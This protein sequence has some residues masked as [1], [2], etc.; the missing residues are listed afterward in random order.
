MN[1]LHTRWAEARL[2]AVAAML[3]LSLAACA[4]TTEDIG[5]TGLGP[6]PELPS[7]Q[8]SL[9][10]TIN[11]AP[12]QTRSSQSIPIAPPGFTVTAFASGLEH[13]RWVYPLPDGDLLVA[14][15][16]APAQHDEHGGIVGWVR[17]QVM[18]FVMK[19]AGAGV[20]SPDRIVL[21]RGQG[22][23]AQSRSVLISGLHSPF[24][25]A[26]VGDSLYVADTDALL[27]FPY[28]AGDTQI[29]AA[30]EKVADLPAGPINHHWTKNVV[31]S[32]D[33]Q[34]LYVTVGSNSNVGENGIEAEEGRAMILEFTAATGRSRVFAAGL[35]N[36]NGMDWQPE[37]GA[38][39]AAVNERDELGDNLVPDYMTAVKDGGFYGF[40]YSYYGQHVDTR[41]K[42]QRPD[43]VASALT[44]DYALGNHT[45][46]LGL[47]FYT[48]RSFPQHYWGGA[49]VGQHGSW[50]RKEHSG[51]KVVFVP[52]E[53]GRPAGMPETFLSGFLSADGHALGRPVG[54]A[55]DKAGALYVA[56]DVGNVVWK[57]VYSGK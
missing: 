23:T 18:K 31:A 30:G 24:G 2:G 27:R 22:G 13:P 16:N 8:T 39:W 5:D 46:S 7:P 1:K 41:V 4:S 38:L 37:S 36:P 21:L 25:M 12:V 35:R 57:V 50:N 28:R 51:Y 26:L 55:V 11:I 52:F 9:L 43:K 40:P 45:A 33:G 14:E 53:H 29:T 42:E 48:G 19:R 44:P 54:V 32:R 34:R 3:A 6:R 17:K 47:A 15:S 49:F 56:D 20:P 10:P